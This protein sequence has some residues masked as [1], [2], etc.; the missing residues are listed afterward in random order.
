MIG[1][2]AADVPVDID[3]DTARLRAIEELRDPGYAAARPGL[4]QQAANWIGA[5]IEE[6]LET[7]SQVVPGGIFGLLLIVVLLIVLA[8]VIRLRV[9]KVARASRAS[10][11]VFHGARR[12]AADHRRA[13][14]EAAARG[15]FAD[16]VRERF[17]AVVR[18]LEER[19]VL[20]VRSG[21]T[22]D[23]AAA[24]AGAVLRELAGA[25]RDGARRFDDVHYGGRPGTEDSYRFLSDLD[26]RCR[27]AR[28]V[29]IS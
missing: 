23:E 27:K 29:A 17:R 26:D 18:D 14:A 12:N 21:R 2:F 28:P 11:P 24:E 1:P 19:A 22:A 7:V 6:F 8:V 4:L 20:D 13:S 25:L 15:D 10:Q 3:R 5:R 16:A 9:G